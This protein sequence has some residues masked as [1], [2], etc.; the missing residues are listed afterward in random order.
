MGEQESGTCETCQHFGPISRK[1][2]YYDVKCDCCGNVKNQHFEI[3]RH[4]E[5]CEPKSPEI[6]K[7]KMK[8]VN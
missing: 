1:Y 5:K 4:C 2:Y 8:P 7:V 3:V 6:I